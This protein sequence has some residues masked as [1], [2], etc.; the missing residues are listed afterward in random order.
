MPE[1]AERRQRVAAYGVCI[2]ASGRVLLARAALSLTI[3]GRWFLPGGGL[4]HGESPVA[5]LERE[6]EEET[7]LTVVVGKLRRVLSD[8]MTLPSQVSLHTIRLIYDIA[9]FAGELRAE[10]GGSTDAVRWVPRDQVRELPIMPY[11]D[12][13]L[14][15]AEDLSLP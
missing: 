11:V 12:E 2:D 15:G 14:F 8:T 3:A 9:S 4:D 13:A 1:G 10:V 6:F 7:G 5:G